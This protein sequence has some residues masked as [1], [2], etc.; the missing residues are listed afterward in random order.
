[1]KSEIVEMLRKKGIDA[2][3]V[4]G[5]LNLEAFD[6]LSLGVN[7]SP[8][9]FH[10]FAGRFD[11]LVVIDVRQIGFVRTYSAYIPTSD[12]KATLKGVAYMV[13]LKT[14]ALDWY[15]NFYV[16]KSADGNWDEAPSFPGL[17][18]AYFQ[19]IEL[20]KD[21]LKQPFAG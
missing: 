20:G 11:R 8:K 13:D 1:M 6:D 7:T 12:A 10:K 18:N 3:P 5:T 9:D 2:A 17:T 19:V 14:N 15:D 21:Q 16:V 4:D